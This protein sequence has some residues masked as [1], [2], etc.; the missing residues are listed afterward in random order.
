MTDLSVPPNKASRIHGFD[1]IRTLSFVAISLH[2]FGSKLWNLPVFS[3]FSASF[4]PWRILETYS[5]SISF[6]GQ[7]ILFLTSL[8]IAMTAKSHEKALRM[9]PILMLLWFISSVVDYSED[10]LFLA[11]DIF[12]LIAVGLILAVALY[13]VRPD[14]KWVLPLLG[15]ILICIPFWK[16]EG[17]RNLPIFYRQMIVGDCELDLSDWPILPWMGLVFL[18]YG[19]GF[20]IKRLK[21][22]TLYFLKNEHLLWLILLCWTP[23]FWGTYYIMDLGNRYPC[24][25]MRQ[26]PI[27]F[28]AHLFPV[29]F[30][31]RISLLSKV[32]NFLGNFKL[33]T[34][35]SKL[36]I[37]Q[38]FG[39]AY[40]F[41]FFLI[42]LYTRVSD[43]FIEK[44]PL[45]SFL[46]AISLLPLTEISLRFF[47]KTYAYVKKSVV[48]SDK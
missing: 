25:G 31:L 13:K 15:F 9:I 37:N 41:H 38:N 32:R 46:A 16:F 22:K 5:R 23:L 28:I 29:M 19:L 14:D 24:V 44:S 42:D 2:H 11:W 7:T 48:I 33:I 8:L 21:E 1:L 35:L 10:S 17:L 40:F 3:P 20:R 39:A 43:G 18:G 45:L 27:V 34:A 47:K 30:L 26:E 12:P 36:Q 6:S 4:L